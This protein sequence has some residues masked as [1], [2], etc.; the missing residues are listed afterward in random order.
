MA[1]LSD[2]MPDA[3]GM[4]FGA[5]AA[6][7]GGRRHVPERVQVRGDVLE[8]SNARTLA[9]R[10]YSPAG[11]TCLR[12]F[13]RLHDAPDTRIADFAGRYGPLYL[14]LSGRPVPDVKSLPSR[15]DEEELPLIGPYLRNGTPIV[16]HRI[17]HQEP[18]PAW[19]A[20][21]RYIGILLVLS[22]ALR[23]EPGTR[24]VAPERRLRAAQI[25]PGPKNPEFDDDS[26]FVQRDETDELRFSP[27]GWT[28]WHWLYPWQVIRELD[29]AKSP[30][31]QWECLMA[32]VSEAVCREVP[33]GVALGG[34]PARPEVTLLPYRP[35]L[36][37]GHLFSA[38]SA[39]PLVTGQL[40]AAITGGH[41][42][43][44]CASCHLPYPV[45]RRRANGRCPECRKPARSA[46]VQRSKA[47]RRAQVTE[48][49]LDNSAV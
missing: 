3:R 41:H 19:R 37:F 28:V 2:I 23:E 26:P 30:E 8:W 1:R 38:N 47:K 24:L 6:V 42:T 7:A 25:D 15:R 48:Q 39:F 43:Q 21:A 34:T 27:L 35:P 5:S 13:V 33:Y 11:G 49:Q 32:G 46:S 29:A 9:Q 4:A 16:T 18:I 45:Q 44:F 36:D 12:A 14:G 20:W 10:R 17:W 31:D 22:A 40:L